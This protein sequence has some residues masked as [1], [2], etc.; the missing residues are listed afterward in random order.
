V[1]LPQQFKLVRQ[2]TQ[3]VRVAQSFE[4]SACER[5]G[6]ATAGHDPNLPGYLILDGALDSLSERIQWYVEQRYLTN[7]S[8]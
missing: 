6:R 2:T 3:H 8:D 7:Q 5:Q 4:G 1:T